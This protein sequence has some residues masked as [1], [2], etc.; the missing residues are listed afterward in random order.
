M[1]P[2]FPLK[3]KVV[4]KEAEAELQ[5][6]YVWSLYCTKKE[7]GL[8]DAP[9]DLSIPQRGENN[10]LYLRLSFHSFTLILTMLTYYGFSLENYQQC[11][12]L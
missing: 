1:H 10:Q 11:S 5:F 4:H 2:L 9:R 6:P 7:L 3:P 8:A 12:K